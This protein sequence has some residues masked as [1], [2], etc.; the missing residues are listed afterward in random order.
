[1]MIHIYTHTGGLNS[2][3]VILVRSDL[4]LWVIRVDFAQSGAKVDS[5]C[6]PHVSAAS[7][8]RSLTLYT[9][10]LNRQRWQALVQSVPASLADAGALTSLLVQAWDL[11]ATGKQHMRPDPNVHAMLEA[12]AE[13]IGL[14]DSIA[15]L[16]A[17]TPRS[18]EVRRLLD[19]IAVA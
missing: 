5:W 2:A 14:A 4:G 7:E 17:V 11:R 19:S 16:P 13:R 12:V 8:D 3:A 15:A 10:G 1:M 6:L 18:L 9:S